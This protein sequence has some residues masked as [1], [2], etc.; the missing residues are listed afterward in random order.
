MTRKP[1][2]R[3]SLGKLLIPTRVYSSMARR[4]RAKSGTFFLSKQVDGGT[5]ATGF[6][7]SEID[8]SSFVN[9]LQGEVVRVKQVW[10][11]WSDDSGGPIASA[12][13]GANNGAS[14]DAQ[15]TV[16]SQ[17]GRANFTNNAVMAKN[18]VYTH[19]AGAGQMDFYATEMGMNPTDY[20]DGY[21]VATDSI[22]LG[23]PESLDPF[24]NDIRCSVKLECE[25]VKLSLSDAQAVLVSQTIG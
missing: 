15:V 17:T 20:E 9:V 19:C 12:S 5:T 8:I 11:Q 1:T 16:E 24:T 7:Q 6:Q 25:I 21:L 4:S 14:A 22:Y 18:S 2:L 23:M 13:I 10:F 3:K